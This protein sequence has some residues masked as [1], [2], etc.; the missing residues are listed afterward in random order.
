MRK[1]QEKARVSCDAPSATSKDGAEGQA[2]GW[3]RE[4]AS[5]WGANEYAFYLSIE[6]PATRRRAD[7]RHSS[8]RRQSERLIPR[9]L[10]GSYRMLQRINSLQ[11]LFQRGLK[12]ICF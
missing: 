10:R 2:G 11:D 1:F 7:R 3:Q 8:K 6:R 9:P 12:H 4:V 5:D